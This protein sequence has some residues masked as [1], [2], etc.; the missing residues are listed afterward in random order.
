MGKP[1]LG[2]LTL[3]D[4]LDLVGMNKGQTGESVLA[5]KYWFNYK[6]KVCYLTGYLIT[7]E[8]DDAPNF[9]DDAHLFGDALD[10]RSL[11]TF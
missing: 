3:G 10:A 1:D 11:M 2:C 7:S 6:S 9:R 5:V 8:Y 4:C